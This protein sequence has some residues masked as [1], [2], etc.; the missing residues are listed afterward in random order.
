MATF[1]KPNCK[2]NGL[3]S[4]AGAPFHSSIKMLRGL[5]ESAVSVRYV[6]FA[7][8]SK[9][10]PKDASTPIERSH[11]QYIQPIRSLC[12]LNRRRLKCFLLLSTC[13][14]ISRL[15]PKCLSHLLHMVVVTSLFNVFLLSIYL[16]YGIVR[17]RSV[18]I[19]AWLRKI[20]LLIV[21]CSLYNVC[22]A[23]TTPEYPGHLKTCN[24]QPIGK[25][26]RAFLRT[27]G[28][29]DP[30]LL[31]RN[32]TIGP[33][34]TKRLRFHCRRHTHRR[35]EKRLQR[36]S[37]DS[38]YNRGGFWRKRELVAG[39]KKPDLEGS[40][41]NCIWRTCLPVWTVAT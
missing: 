20:L 25:G 2:E 4:Y 5:G 24:G 35:T 18:E 14:L 19:K 30:F 29:L 31:E 27:R 1:P 28:I 21:Y 15:L 13:A 9:P 39:S 7:K 40:T 36:H 3:I 6:S 12:L 38:T 34:V 41:T 10:V 17:S 37:N 16:Q 8:R 32:K 11:D 26:S 23:G 22:I 33:S